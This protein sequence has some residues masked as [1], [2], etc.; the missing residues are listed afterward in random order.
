MKDMAFREFAVMALTC[1][2][3]VGM[4]Y[5]FPDVRFVR[6]MGVDYKK[7]APIGFIDETVYMGRMNA[8]YKGDFGLRN[9]AIYEH[10]NDPIIMPSLPEMLEAGAGIALGWG[11]AQLDMAATFFL[12]ALLFFLVA[13]FAYRLSRAPYGA[14]ITAFAVMFGMRFFS[15]SVLFYGKI[16]DRAY[17]LPLWFMR[18]ITPQLHFIFFVLA[19]LL[20]YKAVTEKRWLITAAAG[21]SLGA[22]FYVSV[23]YWVYSY[24]VMAVLFVTLIID[25]DFDAANNLVV[26][27]L[28]G[29]A[30]SAPYWSENLKTMK[31]AGYNLLLYRFNIAY[32]H[33]PILSVPAVAALGLLFLARRQVIARTGK[34][35]FFFMLSMAAA[36]LL[37][38][39]QQV[40][41][42]KLFKES[43]WTTYTGKFAIIVIVMT[44]AALLLKAAK[45]R[46]PKL[47]WPIRAI[48]AAFFMVLFIH[49]IGMQISYYGSHFY[50]NM[51]MQK[52]A[53]VFEWLKKNASPEDVILPSPRQVRLSELL[54]IYT[55][56]YV[57]YSEPFF[58][59]SLIPA[60]ETRYRMLAA[61]R[62]FGLTSEE[63]KKHA[64]S[65]DGAVFLTNDSNRE[66][67]Y[68]EG[69]KAKLDAEYKEMA[70][71]DAVK[72]AGKYKVDYILA[73]DGKDSAVIKSLETRGFRKVY[74]DGNYSLIKV[75]DKNG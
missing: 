57:Y 74:D 59:M 15:G 4:V 51:E 46:M 14:I 60:E 26:A 61:Y 37:T 30:V 35:A 28:A 69:E 3:L 70:G 25:G 43:H 23:F 2:V 49:A 12:P 47:A 20:V 39:N 55:N 7:I 40:L 31:D 72:L 63:A 32:T 24:A 62:I 75:G 6:D 64:Y 48:A 8:I 5:S 36:V 41:T 19:L 56:S 65:W 68:V 1:A 29:L 50:E 10:R 9:P 71:K 34:K 53:G 11:I 52:M 17:D 27:G 66:R 67:S 73:V 42:G 21:L 44:V 33:R 38:L 58:C 45:E 54:P 16:V 22:L 18:P 13:L